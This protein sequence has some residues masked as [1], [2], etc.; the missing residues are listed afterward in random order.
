MPAMWKQLQAGTGRLTKNPFLLATFSFPEKR[1]APP[2]NAL[3][4]YTRQAR[5][6]PGLIVRCGSVFFL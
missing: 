4:L 3:R 1:K 6:F 5:R 2:L